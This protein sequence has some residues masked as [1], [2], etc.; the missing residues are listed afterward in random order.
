MDGTPKRSNW[1]RDLAIG[2]AVAL[3][4]MLLGTFGKAYAQDRIIQISGN[5]RTA[6]VTVAI[7]KSQDVRTGSSFV[8]VMVG[9]PEIADVNPLTDHSISIL[10]KKIGTTRVSVYAEGKKLIGIFDVEVTYDIT[11]LTNE[12]RR[13]FGGSSLQ[14]S[15]V[16]GRIM[17]NG[18][19][20]DA[21]TLDKAVT[22]ARQFGPDIIN[23]VS[24][25]SPQQVML[26]VRFIEITR[27]AGRELG[28]QWNRFGGN[29][30]TNIG[31]QL[32]ANQLPISAPGT[33]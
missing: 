31:S 30:T 10:A 7:G 14:A 23:S 20:A 6:M 28:L 9:D 3:A 19:V 25:S 2:L 15:A 5:S 11:R 4:F 21:V 12:L 29:S 32:P 26:E 1:L 8:D 24:V 18:E 13:R 17:L 16:N 33:G 22:I 27:T